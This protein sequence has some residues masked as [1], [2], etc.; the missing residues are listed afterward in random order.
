MI[1]LSSSLGEIMERQNTRI[2]TKK[3]RVFPYS[4]ASKPLEYLEL[5]SSL[6]EMVGFCSLNDT[7]IYRRKQRKKQWGKV[8]PKL[9][10]RKNEEHIIFNWNYFQLLCCSYN[11]SLVQFFIMEGSSVMIGTTEQVE[12]KEESYGY[13]CRL[14]MDISINY[15]SNYWDNIRV[16]LLE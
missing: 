5:S 16:Y 7:L 4:Q 1:N 9:E 11:S 3:V 13:Y 12:C 8:F 10:V 6:G 2:L 14:V 15:W